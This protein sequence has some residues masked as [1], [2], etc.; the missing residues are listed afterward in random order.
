MSRGRGA[1]GSLKQDRPRTE[2]LFHAMT[3]ALRFPGLLDERGWS[4]LERIWCCAGLQASRVIAGGND[5][6]LGKWARRA[7]FGLML[8]SLAGLAPAW[9]GTPA[10]PGR[11]SP[12]GDILATGIAE[13]KRLVRG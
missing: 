8:R 12:H 9:P 4:L 6:L 5:R 13:L 2:F 1:W 11:A 7:S 10:G 3:K